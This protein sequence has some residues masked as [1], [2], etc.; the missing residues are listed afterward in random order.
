MYCLK[1]IN[2]QIWRGRHQ[3]GAD[4]MS[5]G[6]LF[7][8]DIIDSDLINDKQ[9]LCLVQVGSVKVPVIK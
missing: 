1:L 4:H 9:S 3:L 7:S 6:G 8:P 5:Y 2:I